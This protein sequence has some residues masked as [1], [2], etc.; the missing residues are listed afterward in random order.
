[1]VGG[2]T[3]SA[4]PTPTRSQAAFPFDAARFAALVSSRKLE[5]GSP[6]VSR[7]ATRS[8]NDDLLDIVATGAPHGAV[9][10]A[11]YQT[12]GRGRHGRRWSSPCPSENLLFSVLLRPDDEFGKISGFT[13]AMGLAVRQAVQPLVD[14]PVRVKWTNDIYVRERK[15][16]GILVE[17]RFRGES[18][19]AIV[20]GVGLNVHARQFEDEVAQLATSLDLLGATPVP[21]EE[22]LAD[23]LE[24]I[25][26]QTARWKVRGISGILE[27]WQ[28]HDMLAGRWIQWDGCQGIARGIDADGALLV[29]TSQDGPLQRVTR[30]S[31]CLLPATSDGRL[32]DGR[33]GLGGPRTGTG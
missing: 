6:L 21:V 31:I 2:P 14:A 29:E 25:A 12:H 3:S 13:L 28:Q 16:A 30:G 9:V 27:E 18:P 19:T 22:L 15:L 10:Q 5:L 26:L 4:P 33:P 24:Q 17:A 8:T 7:A 11:E 23:V 32:G 20:V 1:M